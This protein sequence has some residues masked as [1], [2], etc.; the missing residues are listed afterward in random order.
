MT[1]L[2]SADPAIASMLTDAPTEAEFAMILMDEGPTG[3]GQSWDGF[4]M[5]LLVNL[6]DESLTG[7]RLGV[8]KQGYLLSALVGGFEYDP[9]FGGSG[10][11]DLLTELPAHGVYATLVPQGVSDFNCSFDHACRPCVRADTMV[12]DGAVYA[13]PVPST[14]ALAALGIATLL[15]RGRRH[16][17]RGIE[18]V[19]RLIS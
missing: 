11:Y 18:T 10:Y 19:T 17:R 15:A 4:D 1:T 13:V 5:L 6:T 9:A 7:P 12:Y 2:S 14:L 16:F 8:G 3:L